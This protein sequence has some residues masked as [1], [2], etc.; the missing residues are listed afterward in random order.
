MLS[1]WVFKSPISYVDDYKHCGSEDT[2][3]KG[4]ELALSSIVIDPFYDNLLV[5]YDILG[6]VIELGK[7]C[8]GVNYMRVLS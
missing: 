8:Q 3:T 7:K 2:R 5:L 1:K 4:I 6:I